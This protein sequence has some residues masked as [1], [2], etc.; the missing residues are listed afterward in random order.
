MGVVFLAENKLM[1]RKEVLKVVASHLLDRKGVLERFLRE[2]RAAA[3][4]HHPNIVT[5]YSATR[6]GECIVFS[7]QYIDGLDLAELVEKNGPLPV[8]QACNFVS[9]AAVGLQHAYERGMV[10]RDIK[11]GNLMLTKDGN[12]PVIKILDF[13]L[14]KVTSETGVEG[15]LTHTGQMLGT[16]QYMAPEQTLDAQKADIRADIYSLGC[17]LYCLLAGRPPFDAPSLYE[18]L[19]AHHSMNP[20]LLSVIRSE[21]PAELGA[22]VAKML[23]KE[24]ENRFQTP[25]EV[26]RALVP[27]FRGGRSAAPGSRRDPGLTAVPPAAPSPVTATGATAQPP[28]VDRSPLLSGR[29]GAEAPSTP[30]SALEVLPIPSVSPAGIS[31][32]VWPAVAAGAVPLCLFA[33]WMLG[34]F[35]ARPMERTIEEQKPTNARAAKL[36]SETVPGSAPDLR[37]VEEPVATAGKQA[38]KAAIKA[39]PLPREVAA[40]DTAARARSETSRRPPPTP[41]PSAPSE[42]ARPEPGAKA[43]ISSP[44]SARAAPEPPQLPPALLGSK[45][46]PVTLVRHAVKLLHELKYVK[47]PQKDFLRHQAI[48][49]LERALRSLNRSGVFASQLVRVQGELGLLSGSTVNQTNRDKLKE[50]SDSLELAVR[51]MRGGAI[52]GKGSK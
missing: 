3:Q 41:R 46:T 15:G 14:A 52:S 9:Q 17:T 31:K 50:A 13:G 11:P 37:R 48:G 22:L 20:E 4:L 18:L 19:Q 42:R 29:P 39:T 43:P 1:G 32:W 12:K 28:L 24:A 6:I 47:Q 49:D 10:H 25:A 40:L 30:L 8:A 36:G 5:A 34:S 27:F 35:N 33:G 38:D 45:P 7:M 44:L 2:I 21:I 23:A 26:A 16:P 51:L